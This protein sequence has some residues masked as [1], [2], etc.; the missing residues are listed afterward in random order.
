MLR[1][2][3]P[4]FVTKKT[5]PTL[6]PGVLPAVPSGGGVIKIEHIKERIKSFRLLPICAVLCPAKPCG[7]FLF[8]RR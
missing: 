4:F 1:M 5:P 7:E 2:G 8:A 3:H 6:L